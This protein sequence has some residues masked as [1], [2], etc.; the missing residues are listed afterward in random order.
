MKAEVL[1]AEQELQPCARQYFNMSRL[2]HLLYSPFLG[3]FPQTELFT[4]DLTCRINVA[5]AMGCQEVADTH[6][7]PL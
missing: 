2:K 4:L 3:Y 5:L 6:L 7:S 1:T